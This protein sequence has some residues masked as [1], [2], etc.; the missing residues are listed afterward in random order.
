[1]NHFTL[2]PLSLSLSLID[3]SQFFV[4]DAQSELAKLTTTLHTEPSTKS[5]TVPFSSLNKRIPSIPSSPSPS[6]HV[7]SSVWS[8]NA[9]RLLELLQE[10]VLKRL[11]C[12]SRAG[13]EK[14]D[15]VK[16]SRVAVLFSGGLDSA[17]IAALADR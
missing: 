10:A 14:E 9:A 4:L 1:M 5:L 3:S 12:S 15:G 17:V 7:V 6:E 16:A 8:T 13:E 11:V 2:S